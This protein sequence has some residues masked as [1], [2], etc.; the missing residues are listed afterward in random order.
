MGDIFRDT[1]LGFVRVHVLHHAAKAPIFGLEMIE[2]L[3]EH[4]YRMS[5]G[6]LYP[7]LHAMESA[8]YLSASQKAVGGKVR[9]YY[10]ATREGR[11]ALAELRAKIRELTEEVLE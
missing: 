7:I 3:G 1:F 11:K 2:E 4:G 6:T 9:K 10:R 8:G 5:P